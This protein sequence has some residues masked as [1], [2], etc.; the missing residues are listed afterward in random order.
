M[1]CLIL[2]L[3]DPRGRAFAQCRGKTATEFAA[4]GTT[5]RQQPVTRTELVIHS[6]QALDPLFRCITAEFLALEHQQ[7]ID[8]GAGKGA[9]F[10]FA[11]DHGQHRAVLA[12][13]LMGQA[14]EV[15]VVTAQAA[16]DHVRHNADVERWRRHLMQRQLHFNGGRALGRAALLRAAAVD[17][18]DAVGADKTNAMGVLADDA[19]GPH[20][21]VLC[22]LHGCVQ[23]MQTVTGDPFGAGVAAD[24]VAHQ[25]TSAGSRLA[26]VDG[27]PAP[28]LRAAHR[29]PVR[30]CP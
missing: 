17:T 30:R 6:P 27:L 18:L 28:G 29:P 10:M 23:R 26:G 21:A 9:L 5:V 14:Q 24:N 8:A 25:C 4:T 12:R 7:A 22:R 20:P 2:D 3:P 19:I 11:K 1:H 16:T 15:A 13:Q